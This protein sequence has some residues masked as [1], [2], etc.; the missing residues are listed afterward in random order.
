MI[1]SSIIES[2]TRPSFYPHKPQT[3]ELVQ[4]HISYVFIAGDYVYKVKKPVN[5]GFLDFTTL[6]Q[7]KFYCEEELRLNR[8]LAPSIYQDVVPIMQNDQGEL[9]P[10][11]AGK[12]IDYAVRMKK[13]PLDKM[14]KILLAQNLADQ[15]IMDAVAGK[16]ARFHKEA[17]TGG[18]ID[19][20]GSIETIR[21]NTDENFAQTEKYLDV[22]IP[23]Y[24]FRFIKEYV[25][26]F[27]AANKYLLEKRVAEHKIRDCHGD[28]HLEHICIADEIIIFDCIEFNERFRFGDVAAEVAFLTMDLDYNGY[29]LKAEDFVRSYL[30]YSGDTDMHALLNFYRCYYAYVRGKVISFRLDQKEIPEAERK[31]I[32]QTASKYFD[33]A[34]TYAARLEK[35]LLILTAGLI[36]SGKSYQALNLAARLGADVI[37]TDVLRKELLNISPVEQHHDAFGQGIYASDISQ[38][39]YEKAI[40]LAAEK[41]QQGKPVIIDASFKNRSDRAL[42]ADLAERLHVPFYVIECNCPDAVVKIRLEKRKLDK[43]NPSDGRWEILQKQKNQYEEIREIPEDSC[44]KV[45]T[46]ANPEIS[47]QNIIRTIKMA[48][49]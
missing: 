4:T 37:R 49:L 29:H 18:T 26:R 7:R 8:R 39:T 40:E 36:G 33:L 2:M 12:I 5:F 45:D 1:H 38:K 6:E 11:G 13:L 47:R 41:I 23:A 15:K 20:M 28:L 43:D 31:E 22:T 24:Q 19:G 10:G 25:E 46:S 44:F 42:A 48:E 32:K 3:V 17:D 16:I 21:H 30:Q 9:S 14:L 34:Y 35:P 27:L